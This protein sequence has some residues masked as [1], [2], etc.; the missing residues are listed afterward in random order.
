M[1]SGPP[2]SVI[3][4][5]RIAGTMARRVRA[6]P[7]RGQGGAHLSSLTS[8]PHRSL[9]RPEPR[10]RAAQEGDRMNLEQLRKQAKELVSAARAGDSAALERLGGEP[11]LARAQL[12]LARE[13]GYSELARAGRRGGGG[14]PRVRPRR[15]V[16]PPRPRRGDARGAARRSRR[17][18]WARLVARRRLGGRRERAGR[19]AR[20]GA[21]ALR[22]LLRLRLAR[23]RAR[24]AGPRRRPERDVQE[25]VRRHAG[26]VRRG[27]RRSTTPS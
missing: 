16:R 2:F 23:P 15:H 12:A 11:I 10:T 3:W 26:A 9:L 24:A 21:A 7:V 13:H 20:L 8:K 5:A 6:H 1:T 22:L 14:R 4:I 19:P 18:P 25:R 17:D 27:R